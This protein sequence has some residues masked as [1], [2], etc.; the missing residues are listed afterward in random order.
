MDDLSSGDK[1][2]EAYF[3]SQLLLI[4]RRE[5]LV[6]NWIFLVSPIVRYYF[7]SQSTGFTFDV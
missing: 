4:L 2:L 5:F 1:Y 6:E 7:F 3:R